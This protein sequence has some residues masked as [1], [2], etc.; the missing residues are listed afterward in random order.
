[1][2]KEPKYKVEFIK[3]DSSLF[4]KTSGYWTVWFE[5]NDVIFYSEASALK[6]CDAFNMIDDMN[7]L[8]RKVRNLSA[9]LACFKED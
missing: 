1:M 5:D 6:A 8:K 3:S 2:A 7:N 4:D 9:A